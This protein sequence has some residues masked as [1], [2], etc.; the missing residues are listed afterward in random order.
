[1]LIS[2]NNRWDQVKGWRK[3]S[4]S[5]NVAV[6]W[7]VQ[8]M[9]NTDESIILYV[10]FISPKNGHSCPCKNCSQWPPIEKTTKG[11]L[12]NHPPPQRLNQS[13]YWTECN[14]V[15]TPPQ[16]IQWQR[17][18]KYSVFTKKMFTYLQRLQEKL[19]PCLTGVAEHLCWTLAQYSL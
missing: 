6:A 16:G 14:F 5:W 12:P 2:F 11:F 15:F 4:E 3:K 8:H 9:F 13:R 18:Q 10:F 19:H 17:H 1:M 7:K